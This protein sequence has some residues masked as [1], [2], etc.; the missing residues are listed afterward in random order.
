VS[1]DRT[2]FP[3]LDCLGGTARE[4]LQRHVEGLLLDA[5]RLRGEA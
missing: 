5:G 3:C 1:T 2:Q 4:A